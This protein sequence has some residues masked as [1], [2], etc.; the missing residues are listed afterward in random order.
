MPYISHPARQGDNPSI[1]DWLRY[2]VGMWMQE[3]GAIL[4]HRALYPND[5]HCRE[6]GRWHRPDFECDGIPF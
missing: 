2:H 3:R 1:L 5:I 4:E 6:C